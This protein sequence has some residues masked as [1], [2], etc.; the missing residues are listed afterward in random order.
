MAYSELG[1]KLVERAP[2]GE[3]VR[4][5]T[6]SR[7]ARIIVFVSL[8]LPG[9]RPVSLR[10]PKISQVEIVSGIETQAANW[11]AAQAIQPIKVVC[12]ADRAE[13]TMFLGFLVFDN[14]WLWAKR[15]LAASGEG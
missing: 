4:G 14:I 15:R 10:S 12:I 6:N 5:A 11:L 8:E 2:E 13:L 7:P 1:G 3:T 9:N